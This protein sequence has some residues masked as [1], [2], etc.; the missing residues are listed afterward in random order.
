M[1]ISINGYPSDGRYEIKLSP[2]GRKFKATVLN[3]CI[4]Y[5]IDMYWQPLDSLCENDEYI[6]LYTRD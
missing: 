6:K 4:K 2:N 5:D 3:N 1:I